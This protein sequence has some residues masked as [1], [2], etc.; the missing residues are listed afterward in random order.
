MVP[1]TTGS[2]IVSQDPKVQRRKYYNNIP[3]EFWNILDPAAGIKIETYEI[4]QEQ[5]IWGCNGGSCRVI[6]LETDGYGHTYVLASSLPDSFLREMRLIFGESSSFSRYPL[7]QVTEAAGPRFIVDA[8]VVFHVYLDHRGKVRQ[9]RITVWRE[10][11]RRIIQKNAGNAPS[12]SR[13][14]NGVKTN[15]DIYADI[16]EEVKAKDGRS[17]TAS[18]DDSAG[19]VAD[20]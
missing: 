13:D 2:E 17:T 10:V 3:E 12:I 18:G 11:S 1:P 14:A 4:T 19:D 9:T 15:P 8:D 6:L 16:I 7:Q 5:E 20:S